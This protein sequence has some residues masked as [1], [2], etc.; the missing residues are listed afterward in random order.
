MGL[1]I[2]IWL[3][4]AIICFPF[5]RKLVSVLSVI[6]WMVILF[7][8]IR[9]KDDFDFSLP[10]WMWLFVVLS[11][12]LVVVRAYAD[13]TVSEEDAEIYQECL[14]KKRETSSIRIFVKT[15]V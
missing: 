12:L 15:V 4:L 7:L 1:I 10:W 5:F 6:F 14:V 2:A 3:V 9:P 8:A 13:I 11:I